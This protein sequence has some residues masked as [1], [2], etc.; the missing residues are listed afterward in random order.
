MQP[1]QRN[2]SGGLLCSSCGCRVLFP[3]T[4]S[5]GL[6]MSKG[7]GQLGAKEPW[8]WTEQWKDGPW[9]AGP[10]TPHMCCPEDGFQSCQRAMRFPERKL[11]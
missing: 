6:G 11:K 8:G 3:C 2:L 4:A 7:L 5:L 1:P 10:R 9:W